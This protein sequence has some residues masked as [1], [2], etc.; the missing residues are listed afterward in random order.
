MDG[1]PEFVLAYILTVGPVVFSL[2]IY[3]YARSA[4]LRRIRNR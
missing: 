2:A 1:N 3:F 4:Y